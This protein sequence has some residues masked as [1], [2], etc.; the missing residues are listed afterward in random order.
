MIRNK[1]NKCFDIYMSKKIGIKVSKYV[2]IIVNTFVIIVSIYV[3]KHLWK[4]LREEE[5][6]LNRQKL[7]KNTELPIDDL[8]L[9]LSIRKTVLITTI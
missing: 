1:L 7:L 5:Q 9:S 4:G 3:F 6:E 2:L 8:L